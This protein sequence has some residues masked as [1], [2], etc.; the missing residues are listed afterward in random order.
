MAYGAR[1]ESVLGESPRGFESP[2]LRQPNSQTA[3]AVGGHVDAPRLR[4]HPYLLRRGV[5][6]II[7]FFTPAFAVLYFLTI[8]NGPWW[9]VTVAQVI[10]TIL[11]AS[12]LVSYARLGVWVT[13]DSI[14]ERGVFGIT[15]RFTRDQL[16]TTVFVNTYHGGWVETV[17]QLFITDPNGKQLIRLRGQFWSRD[18]MQTVMSTLDVPH[19]EIDHPVTNSELHASYPGLLYWF[20]RRPVL[21]AIIF[22]SIL[23][24]G[25]AV[26]Y[27]L[28]V[29]LGRT[30]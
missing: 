16:G 27:G 30:F 11:F 15:Q 21:A 1:L 8:P 5:G 23:I 10:V 6:A 4:P 24:V 26:L 29:V 3:F 13:H 9:A 14:A 2:I 22:A 28:L 19:L 18:I 12:S 7:A 20:E 25:C 17:P